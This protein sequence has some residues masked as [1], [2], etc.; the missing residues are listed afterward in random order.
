MSAPRRVVVVVFPLVPVTPAM[1]AGQRSKVRSI[2]LRTG[3][4]AARARSSSGA[5]HG[6]AGLGQARS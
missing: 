1:G 5:S 4:P 2:S 6:T 3:I